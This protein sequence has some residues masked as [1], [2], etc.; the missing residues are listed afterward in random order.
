MKTGI[1]IYMDLVDLFKDCFYDDPYCKK[2][3][4][5]RTVYRM[6]KELS[7]LIRTDQIRLKYLHGYPVGF[8]YTIKDPLSVKMICD[9]D[10]NCV[11]Q[12]LF[13]HGNWI[14]WVGVRKNFRRRGIAK[15]MIL[16]AIEDKSAIIDISH[17]SN[18]LPF[19][20]KYTEY[21]KFYGTDTYDLY[22]IRKK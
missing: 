22:K 19:V 1:Y 10:H 15:D 5:I 17:G 18:L 21:N 3:D 20:H 13:F 2:N 8:I 9:Y 16:T 12:S 6:K 14:P 7:E 11:T 4:T